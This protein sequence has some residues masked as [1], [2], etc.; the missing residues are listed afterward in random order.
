V[1]GG[2]QILSVRLLRIGGWHANHAITVVEPQGRRREV[3]LRRWARPGWDLEDPDFTTSRE[4]LV[5]G[6]LERVG[7]PAP[8][9]I[10]AD[11][12]GASC[13]VPALLMTRLPG[14][15]PGRVR[16]VDT[17]L[18]QLAEVLTRIH[19]IGAAS[20]GIPAFRT[21]FPMREAP[22]PGWLQGDL[23][24]VSALAVA[25][26]AG[27]SA[28]TFIHRDYHPG[29]TLWR[30]GKLTGVVDWTQASL[31]PVGVDVGSMRWNLAADFGLR[32]SDRFLDAYRASSGLELR[33]QPIWD[34]VTLMDLVL[35]M[36]R[37][38]PEDEMTPLRAHALACLKRIP[39]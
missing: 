8:R 12:L 1:S 29:N 7:L 13:D 30:Y 18:I 36:S 26:E 28:D 37:P 14:H 11:P 20:Q 32:A 31:G 5:L 15:P 25:R 33:D 39:G 34:L 19:R 3:V 27:P 21:Y 16:D 38:G 23:V 10:G 17:F 6:I 4:M 9:L 2:G 35:S 24:W 22:L